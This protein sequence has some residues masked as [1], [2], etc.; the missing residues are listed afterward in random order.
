MNANAIHIGGSCDGIDMP[1]L[2]G[3]VLRESGLVRVAWKLEMLEGR[4][5]LFEE[6]QDKWASHGEECDNRG[7]LDC[8]RWRF[9]GAAG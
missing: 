8:R 9:W 2:P 7:C 3:Y 6:R 1:P 5:A 4:D